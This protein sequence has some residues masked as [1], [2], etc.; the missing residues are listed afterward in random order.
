M[1]KNFKKTWRYYPFTHVFIWRSYNL[2]FLKYTAWQ[3]G[4][5]V[6]LG[7]FSPLTILTTWTI[8]I[9][10]KWKTW[11]EVLSFYTC[12]QQMMIIHY[13]VPEIRSMTDWIFYF[14]LFLPFY[15]LSTWKIK[16]LKKRKK[17]WRYHHF[18]LVYHKWQSYDVWF[19]RYE[20]P[21][22]EFFA[23]FGHSL[24]F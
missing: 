7:H 5:F 9:L 10:K 16:I 4:F 13:T 12:V 2:Q 23:I 24:P 6:I 3:T 1:E 17:D 11:Q 20:A 19:L 15:P 22:T 18:T 21:Q 8:K 14:G